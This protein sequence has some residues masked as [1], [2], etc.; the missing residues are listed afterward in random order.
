MIALDTS[1]LIEALGGDHEAGRALRAALEAGERVVLPSL[2]LYE[3][4]RGPRTP[5]ELAA[6]EALFPSDEALPFGQEEAGIA[7]RLYRSV[8]RPRGRE[9]DLAIAA[10]AMSWDAFLWTADSTDFG[11]VPG[12]RLW[13]ARPPEPE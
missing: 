4:L 13:R 7:A 5:E 8:P 1:V 2:V 12:L 11:D 10:T 9:I 6:Q 3:W